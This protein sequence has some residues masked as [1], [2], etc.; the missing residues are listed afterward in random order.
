MMDE[1]LLSNLADGF[2]QFHKFVKNIFSS[3][4]VTKNDLFFDM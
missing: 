4:L 2:I 1:K 3:K